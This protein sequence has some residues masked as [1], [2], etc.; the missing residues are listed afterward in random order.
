MNMKSRTFIAV[1]CLSVAN[2]AFAETSADVALRAIRACRDSEQQPKCTASPK[3]ISA[4]DALFGN[5]EMAA[6]IKRN[7]IK[8]IDT[9]KLNFIHV[10][11][12]D[13]IVRTTWFL[14]TP[15]EIRDIYC[16]KEKDGYGCITEKNDVFVLSDSLSPGD[17]K[18]KIDSKC[19]VEN[20][21]FVKDCLVDI[22][23]SYDEYQAFPPT[24]RQL[25]NAESKLKAEDRAAK[26]RARSIMAHLDAD[27]IAL[28]PYERGRISLKNSLILDAMIQRVNY[29][30]KHQP[31]DTMGARIGLKVDQIT[32]VVARGN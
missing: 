28:S 19:P 20:K 31:T 32:V 2:V 18:E 24:Q 4:V 15:I 3:F 8:D 13:L 10:E 1:A 26:S 6:W 14:K 16:K 12:F 22:R 30:T 9:R 11:P 7:T 25:K 21:S 29:I 27:L 17:I 23:I 5:T